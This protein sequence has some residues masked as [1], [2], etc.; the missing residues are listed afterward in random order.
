[1][2]NGN[3]IMSVALRHDPGP[4]AGPS[5]DVHV[6]DGEI[7]M[8]RWLLLCLLMACPAAP[9]WGATPVMVQDFEKAPPAADGVGRQHPER[10]CLGPA[11]DRSAARRE[12]VP[13]AALPLRRRRGVSSTS[14][15]RTRSSIQAPVHKL[16]FWLK[17]DNS[18]CSY[19]LQ[20]TDASGE[21]HQYRSLSTGTG[22]GGIIDFTGWKEVVFDLD[23]PHE[24]WGGDKNGK[25]DSSDHRDHLDRRP[26][27]GKGRRKGEAAGRRGRPV[28]RFAQRRFREERGGDVGLPG[29]GGLAGVLLRRARETRPSP[30]RPRASRA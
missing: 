1:M 28:L 10:E 25:L 16:R 11:L 22:Q 20:V 19:G 27:G 2:G 17:G 29:V 23:A 7:D 8:K 18:K 12:A 15:S 3:K 6:G 4:N 21:T 26:A 9:S 30:S 13:E 14:A 24:T 5:Q